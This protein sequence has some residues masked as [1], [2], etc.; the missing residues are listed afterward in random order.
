LGYDN[1]KTT[2][3]KLYATEWNAVCTDLM[4]GIEKDIY[5]PIMT[6]M[7]EYSLVYSD[8]DY[9]VCRSKIEAAAYI[10]HGSTFTVSF[11][12]ADTPNF[13]H[14]SWITLKEYDYGTYEWTGKMAPTNGGETYFG[15]ERRH[16]WPCEG[17]ACFLVYCEIGST[18][19]YKTWT[20]DGAEGETGGDH[21]TQT[22]VNGQTWADNADH[23]F[24]M[25]WA[26]GNCKF[27]VDDQL[28]SEHTT[29]V[30]SASMG[31]FSEALSYK[32]TKGGTVPTV[33]AKVKF[34]KNT[35]EKTA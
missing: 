16:G 6:R 22:T 26:V 35:L 12:S 28:I 13:E 7:T 15:F 20:S 8:E 2:N 30:P 34:K 19:T 17:I 32:Y 14:C 23:D 18:L 10:V 33:E 24:K 11:N 1:A 27:Y 3:S 31:F 25:V 5:V 21:Q 29:H 4:V 9:L